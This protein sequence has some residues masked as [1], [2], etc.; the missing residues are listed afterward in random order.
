[1]ITFLPCTNFDAIARLLDDKRLGGQRTEA[2][3]ILKWLR[4]PQ[5]Y[6]KL[7]KAGYCAMWSGYEE[8]LV[9]YVNAML[10]EWAMRGKKNDLLQP[11]DAALGLQETMNPPMPPWLGEERL[12]SCH[13]DAL[14]A[15]LPSHYGRLGWSETGA[16]Y[17]GSYLW[18]ERLLDGSWVLRWPKAMKRPHIP[19]SGEPA[20]EAASSPTSKS[21]KPPV[22]SGRA[23]TAVGGKRARG[24]D[25]ALVQ[26]P[27]SLTGAPAADRAAFVSEW[28]RLTVRSLPELAKTHKWPIRFDHCFQRVALDS[29]FGGC[30]YDHL[31]KKGPAI[32]QIGAADLGR[33]V[34]AARRMEEEGIAAVREMDEASLLW[35]D[36]KPKVGGRK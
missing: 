13:R 12:H 14:I 15:K 21:S 7:V 20:P 29:A 23:G 35:R 9:K 26:T 28:E 8:A 10:R 34:A 33:A 19:I 3:A 17:D 16:A 4:A 27:P 24:L 6:P 5:E 25:A 22:K 36:K 32:K 1:M 18:P 11:G 2:W 30:W 31:R